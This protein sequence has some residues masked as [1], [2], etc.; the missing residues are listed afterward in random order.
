MDSPVSR[1]AGGTERMIL[2][3]AVVWCLA[4]IITECGPVADCQVEPN[5]WF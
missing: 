2:E 1:L 4:V 3:G 5:Q